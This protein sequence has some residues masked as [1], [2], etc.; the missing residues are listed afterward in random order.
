MFRTAVPPVV[1]AVVAA[2]LVAGCSGGTP[3]SAPAASSSSSS[4]GSPS[5]V[6]SASPS[7]RPRVV[8]P[9]PK[10]AACYRLSSAQLTR[11]TNDSRPVP[12]SRPYTA[13]TVHVGRLDTVVAGHSVAVDSDVVQRQ[14]ADTCRRELAS[15][16]GG[17]ETTRRL[18]RLNVAWFSPTLAQSERGADWFRCDVVAFSKGDGLLDLPRPDRLKGLLS[19]AGALDTYGLCGTSAPAT[20]G[21]ERVVCGRRHAWRAISTIDLAGGSRYP[22][23]ARVRSA[24]DT[25]CKDA[26][27]SRAEDTLKFS[28]GWEWPTAAQWAAGQHF[29]YCWAPG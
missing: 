3:A 6:S 18:S 9:A 22:G 16:V 28:Y 5:G 10:K 8:P 14:L 21:F 27:R 26:A 15:Y 7:P 24:G 1:G 25:G 17:S 4:T 11:P 19:R 23:A 20:R 13:R 2:V 29:G 12:C